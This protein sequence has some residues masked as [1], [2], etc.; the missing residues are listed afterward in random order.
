MVDLVLGV[1]DDQSRRGQVLKLTKE[2]A[3]RQHPDLVVAPNGAIR[4]D[5]SGGT[6]AAR[7]LF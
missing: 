5:K 3:R 1:F 4:K 2:Q 6:F 7:V